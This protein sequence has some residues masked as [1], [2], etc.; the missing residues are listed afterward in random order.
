MPDDTDRLGQLAAYADVVSA[1]D[2]PIGD[3]AGGDTDAD[4]VIHMPWFDYSEDVLAFIRDMS[5][6]GWVHP[7]D[8]SSWASTPAAQRLLRE[9]DAVADATESDL[10]KILTTVVR[11]DRFNEGMI[12][13]AFR[14]GIIL[15]VTRRAAVLADGP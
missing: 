8:W 2:F 11:G 13:D 9:P 12:A 7:F 10:G 6:L 3:W 15:A 14:R 5:R 4:G 1:P